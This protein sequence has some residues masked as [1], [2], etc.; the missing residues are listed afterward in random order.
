MTTPDELRKRAELC[1]A[2]ARLLAP[3]GEPEFFHT[4]IRRGREFEHD[5]AMAEVADGEHASRSANRGQP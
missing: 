5:A 4:L 2:L 3:A 1:F